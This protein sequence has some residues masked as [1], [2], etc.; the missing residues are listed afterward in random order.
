MSGHKCNQV[1]F[2]VLNNKIAIWICCQPTIH[3][4]SQSDFYDVQTL[5][6]TR[7]CPD[8]LQT[9]YLERFIYLFPP[10]YVPFAQVLIKYNFLCIYHWQY[11]VITTI[12][13]QN[14]ELIRCQSQNFLQAYLPYKRRF[15]RKWIYC[16]EHFSSF[17]SLFLV[18]EK[19]ILLPY[20]FLFGSTS[21]RCYF[22]FPSLFI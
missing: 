13:V 10:G 21:T 18:L 17:L 2:I 4:N 15:W 8:N 11:P 14:F 6:H 9:I 12:D 1:L 16:T 7:I 20:F 3:I 5:V 19:R 22:L